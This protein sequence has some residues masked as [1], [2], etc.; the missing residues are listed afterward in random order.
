MFCASGFFFP[1]FFFFFS[2]ISSPSLWS[3]Y[4]LAVVSFHIFNEKLSLKKKG[5]K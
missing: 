5:S 2:I 4:F 3:F 1:F